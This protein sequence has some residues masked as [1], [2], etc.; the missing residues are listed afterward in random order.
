MNPF[1]YPD[2]PHVRRHSPGGYGTYQKYKAWLRDEFHFRCVYCLQR[3]TWARD[4][5]KIFSVDHVVPQSDPD[6]GGALSKEYTNLVLACCLCNTWRG[7]ADAIDPTREAMAD[8]LVVTRGGL[9]EGKT[10]DGKYLVRLLKLNSP[11]HVR[12]R[13]RVLRIRDRHLAAPQDPGFRTDYLETFGYPEDLPDLRKE[14]G[15]R[16]S[17]GH[18]YLAR[19]EQGQLKDAY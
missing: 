11:A 18:C 8:H 12:E 7:D 3:E 14:S 4:G 6:R 17:A 1:A 10:A 5:H 19:R 16:E 13:L 2:R 15:S 9:V